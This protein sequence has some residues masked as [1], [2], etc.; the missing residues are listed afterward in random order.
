MQGPQIPDN[1]RPVQPLDFSDLLA[2]IQRHRQSFLNSVQKMGSVRDEFEKLKAK[3]YYHV[4]HRRSN[5]LNTDDLRE[6]CTLLPGLSESGVDQLPIA[7]ARDLIDDLKSIDTKAPLD[8]N[9]P[10]LYSLNKQIARLHRIVQELS[11]DLIICDLLKSLIQYYEKYREALCSPDSNVA[12]LLKSIPTICGTDIDFS[13]I[14]NETALK[15]MCRS[16]TGEKLRPNNRGEASTVK[17]DDLFFKPRMV[18]KAL[19]YGYANFASYLYQ[20]FNRRYRVAT[21]ATLFVIWG[22]E[23]KLIGQ[24]SEA[25]RLIL[26]YSNQ[27]P[28]LR[29]TVQSTAVSE[30][31]LYDDVLHL[32][33]AFKQWTKV[34]SRDKLLQLLKN[35]NDPES[36]AILKSTSGIDSGRV[37]ELPQYLAMMPTLM[38]N[39][40]LEKAIDVIPVLRK[41]RDHYSL[42]A[43][44]VADIWGVATDMKA[45]NQNACT[46]VHPKTQEVSLYVEGFDLDKIL[47]RHITSSKKGHYVNVRSID[48]FEDLD[49]PFVAE[50]KDEILQFPAIYVWLNLMHLAYEDEK[51]FMSRVD[52]MVFKETDRFMSGDSVLGIPVMFNKEV[53]YRMFR[54]LKKMQEILPKIQTLREFVKQIQPLLLEVIELL[55]AL[56]PDNVIKAYE[57][58][59]IGVTIE[60]VY[61]RSGKEPPD[62]SRYTSTEI[63]SDSRTMSCESAIA[64]VIEKYHH[65]GSVEDQYQYLEFVG[66][67]FLSFIFKL[68]YKPVELDG[69]LLSFEK[70]MFPNALE[71]LSQCGANFATKSENE[72]TVLHRVLARPHLDKIFEVRRIISFLINHKQVDLEVV[73]SRGSTPLIAFLKNAKNYPVEFISFVIGL[74]VQ[75]GIDLNKEF[76]DKTALDIAIESDAPNI[77]VALVHNRGCFCVDSDTAVDFALRY[78]SDSVVQ[79]AVKQ[80][81]AVNPVFKFEWALKKVSSSE[82]DEKHILAIE[83]NHKARYY[84]HS[85]VAKQLLD[86]KGALADFVEIQFDG[87]LLFY[88]LKEN[89]CSE[90][91]IKSSR[92]HQLVKGNGTAYGDAFKIL[93]GNSADSQFYLI[94]AYDGMTLDKILK[95]DDL[96]QNVLENLDAHSL[97]TFVFVYILLGLSASPKGITVSLGIF[98]GKSRYMLKLLPISDDAVSGLVTH[99]DPERMHLQLQALRSIRLD[100]GAISELLRMDTYALLKSWNESLVSHE[101]RLTNLSLQSRSTRISSMSPRRN[102]SEKLHFQSGEMNHL[103]YRHQS[104]ID[105]LTKV[106]SPDFTVGNFLDSTMCLFAVPKKLEVEAAIPRRV[107]RMLAKV[108]P[109][110]AVAIASPRGKDSGQSPKISIETEDEKPEVRVIS[111]AEAG[112]ELRSLAEDLELLAMAI[113]EVKVGK[114]TSFDKISTPLLKQKVILA[115]DWRNIRGQE[116]IEEKILSKAMKVSFAEFQALDCAYFNDKILNGI[117]MR[118]YALRVLNLSGSQVIPENV[119]TQLGQYCLTISELILD[120]TL[121]TKL[122]LLPLPYLTLLSASSCSELAE[123]EM[124]APGIRTL[125]FKSSKKLKSIRMNS[126]NPHL[127]S[128]D[129]E[130]CELLNHDFLRQLA[131]NANFLQWVRHRGTPEFNA[132]GFVSAVCRDKKVTPEIAR[133]LIQFGTLSLYG[134]NMPEELLCRVVGYL[135]KESE[136]NYLHRTQRLTTLD[137][138]GCSYNSRVMAGVIAR[139]PTLERIIFQSTLNPTQEAPLKIKPRSIKAVEL[140]GV[141]EKMTGE[142]IIIEK[143][144]LLPNGY[145]IIF[146]ND[147]SFKV[148]DINGDGSA[149]LIRKGKAGKSFADADLLPNNDLIVCCDGGA[150]ILS[151]TSWEVVEKLKLETDPEDPYYCVK[152]IGKK[153]IVLGGKHLS[154]YEISPHGYV[155]KKSFTGLSIKSMALTPNHSIFVAQTEN[156]GTFIWRM[157]DNKTIDEV[158]LEEVGKDSETV[159]TVIVIDNINVMLVDGRTGDEMILNVFTK[160]ITRKKH[161]FGLGFGVIGPGGH[162]LLGGAKLNDFVLYDRQSGQN[163][164]PYK[165]IV[166]TI[167]NSGPGQMREPCITSQGH[168]LLSVGKSL[169]LVRNECHDLDLN[170][171]RL[172][173]STVTVSLA[174]TLDQL[175]EIT[176]TYPQ[177]LEAL[178]NFLEVFF[179]SSGFTLQHGQASTV[180]RN[181]PL[182]D[183][184]VY[185]MMFES[186]LKRAKDEKKLSS[187]NLRAQYSPRNHDADSNFFGSQVDKGAQS[188]GG[189]TLFQRHRAFTTGKK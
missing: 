39:F 9:S 122:L 79:E 136:G 152:V 46:A 179:G 62:L 19:D 1:Y 21:P 48:L 18:G 180:I 128:V 11:E 59:H 112:N 105:I 80:M 55:K 189:K 124:D 146:Y 158:Q 60:E 116:G 144:M 149:K 66:A 101:N 75:K 5:G 111:L 7:R 163:V 74:F 153:R 156:Q 89:Q 33:H 23:C 51:R 88:G 170:F 117:L 99:T 28:C 72:E 151:T 181:I 92:L 115:V 166:R 160:E 94:C 2:P 93:E 27:T 169:W 95:N 26:E 182:E 37:D 29:N 40:S 65:E 126:K 150:K 177:N 167:F 100:T 54:M 157:D 165:D 106:R 184:C 42:C 85:D 131:V 102:R 188:T 34:H 30:G 147:G 13:Q 113:A 61:R 143:V 119:L 16:D 186:L 14:D 118:S 138:R 17:E 52:Q 103:F 178:K 133:S 127:V 183:A 82:A 84:L 162:V 24:P 36:L 185:Q 53:P 129:V 98:E 86:E 125:N 38:S 114:F 109:R 31:N 50:L 172:L 58:L 96:R 64:M 145:T 130:E 110:L 69:L 3:F 120:R 140:K 176:I 45:D 171:A 81:A 32:E 20:L 44:V 76:D 135:S 77:F 104:M 90:T 97:T 174:R 57:E 168:L 10:H 49:I 142:A 56:Y 4:N 73:C 175:A 47:A 134:I 137:L 187:A 132:R 63:E 141:K 70:T 87:C 22:V 123:V 148:C 35:C 12:D 83:G 71:L 139:S 41:T 159:N 68:N 25:L 155:F 6:L 15:I 161:A 121:I 91:E 173:P 107:P 78:Q 154:V 43:K 108:S 8:R 67:R 164:C